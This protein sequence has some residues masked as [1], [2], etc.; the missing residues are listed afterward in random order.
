MSL[1]A[2]VGCLLV[3]YGAWV[4]FRCHQ[5]MR[6]HF[7]FELSVLKKHKLV[8]HGPYNVV[9]HPG[10]AGTATVYIGILLW[11]GS[12]G[13]W[14]RESGVLNTVSGS[15]YAGIILLW[16]A[17]IITSLFSRMSK[18][19][20]QLKQVFGKEWENYANRVPYK[21]VPGLF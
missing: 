13:S 1:K 5:T 14:L 7:T 6:Q 10:Y 8:T 12:K 21:L 20:V 19:D 18:E 17:G 16:M 2:F 11:L 4:R 9:R 15:I 3:L